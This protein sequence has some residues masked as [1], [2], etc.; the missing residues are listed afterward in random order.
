MIGED[1]VVPRRPAPALAGVLLCLTLAGCA[2][3]SPRP[4]P[5]SSEADNAADGGGTAAERPNGLPSLAGDFLP[6]EIVTV[7][8]DGLSNAPIV[9]LRE[10]TTGQV[11]PIWVGVAEARA[12]AAALHEVELPRPM[13]HD[14]MASLLG[15]LD[16]RVVDLVIHDL[17]D[18]TYYA[19]LEI[20]PAGGGAPLM[21]D[22][23]PSDGMALALR[24]GAPIRLGR[25]ILAESPDF[26]F[27]APEGSSQ[28]VRAF[29]LTVVSRSPELTERFALPDRAGLV[30]TRATGEAAA[31]GLQRGDLLVEINGVTPEE[32]LDLL[33]AV[34]DAP[35]D[36][37]IPVTYWRDGAEH[38]TELDP[39]E[40]EERQDGP[41]QRT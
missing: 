4:A 11:V 36:R 13:T 40:R 15:R 18:G 12:I 14:L 9:L 1:F 27:L 5:Q 21:V 37:P 41:T 30:V 26:E 17:V 35:L 39:A 22:T 7:G 32:P 24:V 38:R 23:R 8:W 19:L 34:E 2:S 3:P 20:Q 10:T 6:A 33:D 28:V 31:R 25:S 29:G 16:A